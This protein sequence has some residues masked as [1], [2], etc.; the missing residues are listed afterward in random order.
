MIFCKKH[1]SF[2]V[3]ENR[4]TILK[5]SNLVIIL[6]YTGRFRKNKYFGVQIYVLFR[7]D[8]AEPHV[9]V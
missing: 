5:A 7:V 3:A 2:V 9:L 4:T 6:S 1:K 8:R